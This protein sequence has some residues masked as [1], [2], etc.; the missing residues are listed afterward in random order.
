M[1]RIKICGITTPEDAL[2][3]AHAGAD[4][5]GLNFHP[6]SPRYVSLDRAKAIVSVIPA[7]VAKVGLFVNLPPLEACRIFDG[8]GLDLIQF[9]GDESPSQLTEIG[10]RPV[11][12]AFR[13][14]SAGLTDVLAYLDRCRE[15]SC[16]PRMVLLDSQVPGLFG[17]SG[18]IGDW[19]VLASY[20]RDRGYPPFA[21]AGGLTPN[22]VCEA[23]RAVQPNAVDTASG[24]ERSPGSKSPELISE[25][26]AR[27]RAALDR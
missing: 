2:L 25:F 1:F 16:L 9:H 5:I 18:Q 17:G 3:V 19:S 13:V 20:P 21:L 23:I 12:K 15:L 14:D 27:A 11:M 10:H 22:N 8:L 4:A 24:V 26:V 7:G 6:Q